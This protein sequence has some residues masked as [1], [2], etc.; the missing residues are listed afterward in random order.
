MTNGTSGAKQLTGLNTYMY[1]PK[2]DR[3]HRAAWREQ[4]TTDELAELAH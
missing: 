1:S 3:K 2:D 4:Y